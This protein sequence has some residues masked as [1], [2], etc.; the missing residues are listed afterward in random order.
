MGCC[1]YSSAFVFGWI[2]FILAS[3]KD[4][5]KSLNEFEFRP[6]PVTDPLSVWK[7]NV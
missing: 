7:I 4:N 3:N 5:H 1:D 2:F 6:A